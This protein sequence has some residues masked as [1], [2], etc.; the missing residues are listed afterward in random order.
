MHSCLRCTFPGPLPAGVLHAAQPVGVSEVL[1][2]PVSQKAPCCGLPG[3]GSHCKA[4]DDPI[5][6][7]LGGGCLDLTFRVARNY[8]R[9]KMMAQF[10]LWYLQGMTE[11]KWG[12]CAIYLRPS[13]T[14]LVGLQTVR[15]RLASRPRCPQHSWKS[16]AE[17][18]ACIFLALRF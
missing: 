10:P 4:H 11:S 3:E 2:R 8:T 15:F 9:A 18:G 5:G 13:G 7:P 16:S 6:L 1:D 17:V 14:L 12:D